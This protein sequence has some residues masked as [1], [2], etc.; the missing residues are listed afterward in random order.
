MAAKPGE[1]LMNRFH[2]LLGAVT[3]ALSVPGFAMAQDRDL[4]EIQKY[5]L[6][7]AGLAK[8][9][10]ATRKMA[11]LSGEETGACADD[12]SDSQ[13]IDQVVAKINAAP[14]AKAAIQ[15]AGLSTRE[16]V[17]LSFSLLQTGLAAWAV[18]QPGGKLPPG[19]SKANVDFYK[20]H[21]ADMK[22][23]EGLRQDDDCE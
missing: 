6:T 13:S 4:Q 5:V 3:I 10:E 22:Q 12:D 2:R 1:I 20:K 23:L 9:S 8:Y 19:T 11:M 7:D 18:D 15:S 16:Y 17:V 14:A 21:E